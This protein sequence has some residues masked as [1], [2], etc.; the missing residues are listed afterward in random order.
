[1]KRIYFSLF[2][3]MI[4]CAC[5]SAFSQDMV[6]VTAG[7]KQKTGDEI[8]NKVEYMPWKVEEGDAGV[9]EEAVHEEARIHWRQGVTLFEEEDYEGNRILGRLARYSSMDRTSGRRGGFHHD[10]RCI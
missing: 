2:F 5:L 8:E 9:D 10:G 4:F 1:V 6:P 7:T 3:L